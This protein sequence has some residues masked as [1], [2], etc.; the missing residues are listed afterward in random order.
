MLFNETLDVLAL[1]S[2]LLPVSVRKGEVFGQLVT[3]TLNV[4]L[5]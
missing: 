4:Q 3:N 1:L 5:K 2:D